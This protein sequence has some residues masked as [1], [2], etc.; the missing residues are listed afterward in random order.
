VR[1]YRREMSSYAGD[2][3]STQLA[4]VPPRPVYVA[5]KRVAGSHGEVAFPCRLF[6]ADYFYYGDDEVDVVGY[7]FQLVQVSSSG[8]VTEILERCLPLSQ[9]HQGITQR[10]R[11]RYLIGACFISCHLIQAT[12]SH[13]A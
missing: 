3:D 6:D 8:A 9:S 11:I 4:A 13:I 10:I 7:C 5:E 12:R 1:L 2:D